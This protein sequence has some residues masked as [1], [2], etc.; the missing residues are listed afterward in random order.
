MPDNDSNPQPGYRRLILAPPVGWRGSG[1]PDTEAEILRQLAPGTVLMMGDNPELPRMPA[2][3][4]I[5]VGFQWFFIM[6]P[7]A[8]LLAP[9]VV[10]FFN[11]SAECH[12][13]MLKKMQDS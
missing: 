1:A 10:F 8:I 12:A 2:H 9:A 5:E 4:A 7:F 13:L 11:F 6:L 3:R